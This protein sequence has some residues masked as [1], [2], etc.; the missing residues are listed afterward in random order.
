MDENGDGVITWDDIVKYYN[1]KK[2]EEIELFKRLTERRIQKHPNETA[3]WEKN[4]E[5]MKKIVC[6]NTEA[7]I[8]HFKSLDVDN[9]GVISWDEFLNYEA[10][11]SYK[12]NQQQYD[13]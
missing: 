1:K 2:E 7:S 6:Y 4:F 3:R 12:I 10:K 8:K 9:N 5:E 11:L 13:Y